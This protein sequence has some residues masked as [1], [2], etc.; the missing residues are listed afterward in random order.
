MRHDLLPYAIRPG[1]PRVREAA[2]PRALVTPACRTQA[3][4]PRLIAAL[5]AAVPLS[6]VAAAAHQHFALAARA[7]IRPCR[8]GAGPC[9][10]LTLLGPPLQSPQ[11]LV[12][13]AVLKRWTSPVRRCNTSRAL[14][15]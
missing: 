5:N 1:P 13:S 11:R 8:A 7:R 12:R 2:C 9:R 10:R 14:C 6:A 4:T 3:I 15:S